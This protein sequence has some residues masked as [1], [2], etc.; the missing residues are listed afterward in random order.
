MESLKKRK[1][2]TLNVL[3]FIELLFLPPNTTAKLQPMDQGVIRSLKSYFRKDFIQ[4][5][6]LAL[7]ANENFSVSVLDA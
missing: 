5:Y 6:L 4:Q 7:D 1:C 3:S 2:I